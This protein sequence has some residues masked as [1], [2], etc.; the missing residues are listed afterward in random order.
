MPRVESLVETE[1]VDTPE[2]LVI[3]FWM[4]VAELLVPVSCATIM[5]A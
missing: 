1:T 4:V 5:P 2:I 3:S